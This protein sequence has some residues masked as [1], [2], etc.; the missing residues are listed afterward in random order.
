MS[1]INV[2]LFLFITFLIAVSCE[3]RTPSKYSFFIAGHTYGKPGGKKH[4]FYPLFKSEFDSIR[5]YPNNSFGVLTGDIVEFGNE[6]SWDSIDKE[7]KELGLPLFFAPGNHDTYNYKLYKKRYGDPDN[8]YR[9]YRFFRY[10]NDLFILLDANM[11][12]WN[13]SGEQLGFLTDV[14]TANE[15]LVNN[16]FIFAHQLIWWDEYTVFKNIKHNW[17]PYTPDTTNYWGTLEPLF[18]S[19]SSMVFLFAGDLGATKKATP[20]MYYN[21]N[22]I[23]YIGGGM[24]SGLN[25]NYLFVSVDEYGAVQFDLIALQGNR[26]RFGKLEDYILP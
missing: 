23:T 18:Q 21:D 1:K 25:D 3:N 9:T 22:N 4:G 19:Y 13:I 6:E 2:I 26:N 17:P 16:I 20:Y 8:N 11:D 7:M 12:K 14:L 15:G 10:Q 24:G 5:S